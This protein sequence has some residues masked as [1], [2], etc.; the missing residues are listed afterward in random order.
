[1][2]IEISRRSLLLGTAAAYLSQLISGIPKAFAAPNLNLILGRPTNASIAVSLMSNEAISAT[3]E[4]GTT[5]KTFVSKSSTLQLAPNTPSVFDLKNLKSNTRYFYRVRFKGSGSTTTS[6]SKVYS[7]QTQRISGKS[8]SFSL[9]GD[10]HPERAGKMFNSEL[11]YVAMGNVASQNNDFHILL[12]DDF[13]IDPLIGKGQA[14]KANVEKIYRTQRDW[15]GVIGATTPV[16][17]VNGNHEQAAQYLL[18]G[19]STNPAILAGNARNLF[20]PLPAPD[21]FYTGDQLNV[22]GVGL[23]RDYYSWS[24]GDAQFITL[25]P[26]WHS[27]YAVDNVA[28]VDQAAVNKGANNGKTKD[29]WQVGIGDEQYAWLKKTLENSKA[30]YIFVFAHHV[31]GTGRGAV[32]VS[33]DYEW[34]GR[35]PKGTTTFKEQR[36]N[37]ELPIHDLMVKHKVSIFFQGHDHIFVTQER[38]GLIYQSMPN[39]ADDTFSMFNE[40]AY[41]TGTKAANSGHVRVSVSAQEAKVEYF[42][43]ARSKDTNR[44]NMEL[45][46]TYRVAPRNQS[47]TFAI[48]ADPHMD[49]NSDALVYTKTLE[50]VVAA[51]PAFL[52]DL[53]DIF[54]VDKLQNKSEANIRARFELM[55]GYYKKLGSVPLKICLGNHDGELGYSQFNT[56]KYRKEYFPEQTGE[57]AYYSFEGPDQLHIVLDPFTYT[58]SSPKDDGWQW[59]LGKVQYDWLL[60]TLQNSK[61]SHKFI[62][63]HHLLVGNA[64]SRGGVEIAK[65]NE[66]GGNNVDGS[67]GFDK[68]RPGWGKPIH[69]LLKEFKVGFVFKGH[70]HL[71]VKQELDGI[72]YQTLPQPSHPGDKIDVN[73]YGYKSGKGVGGS[74]FLKVST[75]DKTATVEF[76]KFD[77]SIA[78][79]YQRISS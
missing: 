57:L 31:M 52:M 44:K 21:N 46:H 22:P 77:G 6:L 28:G 56:K 26:Y 14:T 9:H 16:F 76:V 73:Q 60:N 49:E 69:E 58:T 54:M 38:D 55:L 3:I 24:W 45:A 72:I 59:T 48:Q 18:D 7:F 33:T 70:D 61:A 20:Y 42:L 32:E 41:K 78:D 36:P 67:Y 74:G 2:N 63:I 62:Y 8:F 43:A 50:Q 71:Y 51:S 68:N 40:D 37:W 35:D 27:K 4:F 19:S 64:T 29:L 39:P 12:G 13:S 17:L 79:K 53:G 75:E 23:L 47:S 66:W 25:D 10:T 65:L 15:L 1:M 30:K 11:Y 5:G 34:G